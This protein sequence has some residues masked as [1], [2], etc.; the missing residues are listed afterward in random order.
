LRFKVRIII[1]QTTENERTFEDVEKLLDHQKDS[2]M[3]NN[4]LENESREIGA[5]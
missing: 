4:E 5:F 3:E 2:E 1:F